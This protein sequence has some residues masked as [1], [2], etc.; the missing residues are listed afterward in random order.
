MKK[1][2]DNLRT[3]AK[4]K[5]VS[6]ESLAQAIDKERSVLTR[7]LNGQIPI[8][9]DEFIALVSHLDVD[10]LSL[11]TAET[12]AELKEVAQLGYI[13]PRDPAREIPELL[14]R[15]EERYQDCIGQE[16]R[17]IFIY[18]IEQ[19]INLFSKK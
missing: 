12:Q 14:K 2:L 8:T 6:H 13:Q 19:I 3:I 11:I 4:I 7:K 16:K 5:E 18:L 10:W 15:F 9:V 17:E 1:Y